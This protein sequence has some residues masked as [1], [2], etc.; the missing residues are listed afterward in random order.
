M[1]RGSRTIDPKQPWTEDGPPVARMKEQGAVFLGK[2]NT[3]E[4]AM[5]SSNEN[6]AYKIVRNPWNIDRVPGG[7][8]GGPPFS[9]LMAAKPDMASASVANPGRWA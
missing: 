6:S 1:G 5:G 7:S 3:D 4:F 2:A 9:P 8:S